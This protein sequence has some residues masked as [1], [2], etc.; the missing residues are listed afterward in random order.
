M[1]RR[2]LRNIATSRIEHAR[3]LENTSA[4][5]GLFHAGRVFRTTL[6]TS[7]VMACT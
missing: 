3:P 5:A 1:T 4:E 2:R 6:A 7:D